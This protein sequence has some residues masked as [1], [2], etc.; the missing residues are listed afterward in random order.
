MILYGFYSSIDPKK[1]IIN[2]KHFFHYMDALKYFATMKNLSTVNF[3]E[4]YTLIQ[5]K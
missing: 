1:E 5:T 2:K 4:L 3:L